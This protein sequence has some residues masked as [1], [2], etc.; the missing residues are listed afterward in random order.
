MN[1]P[2][3]IVFGATGSVGRQVTE[4][5]INAGFAVSAVTRSPDKLTL[6]H[7][8]LTVCKADVLNQQQVNDAIRGH[9]A[10][11]CALGA[12]RHGHLREAGTRNIIEAMQLN[13]VERLIC[14]TT[15]GA[16]DSYG[17]LNFFWKHLMF[18]TILRPV[19]IDHNKQESAVVS[20]GLN[21]TIVRPAAFTNGPITKQYKH[22][23]S[24]SEKNLTFKISRSD[25]ADFMLNLIK[26]D[27]YRNKTVGLSY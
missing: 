14:Q 4:Q 2:K 6:Q 22:G 3:I 1:N 10:V 17:N 25:I 18:G 26:T 8:N 20:S 5:A 16:G 13:G 7:P 15:L 27:S 23:F 9:D 24:G 11:L 21:W 12:G 19:L